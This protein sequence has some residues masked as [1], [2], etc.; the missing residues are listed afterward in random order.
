MESIRFGCGAAVKG[1]VRFQV[2]NLALSREYILDLCACKQMKST[3]DGKSM[4]TTNILLRI[5]GI[6]RLHCF[7]GLSSN[8]LADSPQLRSVYSAILASRRVCLGKDIRANLGHGVGRQGR[9]ATS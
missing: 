5:A 3:K 1:N 6:T 4:S 8:Y 2:T 9:A 7:Y